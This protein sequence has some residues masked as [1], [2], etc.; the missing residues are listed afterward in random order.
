MEGTCTIFGVTVNVFVREEGENL[1]RL[2]DVVRELELKTDSTHLIRSCHF[3]ADKDYFYRSELTKTVGEA[4]VGEKGNPIYVTLLALVRALAHLACRHERARDALAS[5]VAEHAG[6]LLLTPSSA[7]RKRSSVTPEPVRTL[8][9]AGGVPH[10]FVPGYLVLDDDGEYETGSDDESSEDAS[11]G[12]QSSTEGGGVRKRTDLDEEQVI[13]ARAVIDLKGVEHL[14]ALVACGECQG[15]VEITAVQVGITCQFLVTC[16]GSCRTTQIVDGSA[17]VGRRLEANVDWLLIRTLLLPATREIERPLTMFGLRM[18]RHD[19]AIQTEVCRIAKEQAD[20]CMEAKLMPPDGRDRLELCI[21]TQYSR[22]ERKTPAQVAATIGIDPRTS[23]VVG[24]EFAKRGESIKLKHPTNDAEHEYHRSEFVASARFLTRIAQSLRKFPLVIH[25]M[26]TTLD[27][28]VEIVSGGK[29]EYNGS[30]AYHVLVKLPG[31]LAAFFHG[32][33][34]SG[35]DLT[36]LMSTHLITDIA[37]ALTNRFR[38]IAYSQ[39]KEERVN[40]WKSVRVAELGLLGLSATLT[41][42]IADFIVYY[43]PRMEKIA[44]AEHPTTQAVENFFSHNSR[45][46]NKHVRHEALFQVKTHASILSWNRRDNWFLDI[47]KRL[48]NS[49][50]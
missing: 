20:A 44:R 22:S 36:K 48:L 12:P 32:A 9:A 4:H 11:D 42:R 33:H 40:K 6:T 28:I 7:K 5:W 30:D 45:F 3:L 17:R 24:V 2:A 10:D 47:R 25:D 31:D 43:A 18:P 38:Q 26:T 37:R 46:W 21:D 50:L 14:G 19:K 23:S 15:R 1:Y 16:C 29:A 49:L 27:M 13:R 8:S 34:N 39:P 41:E 35:G